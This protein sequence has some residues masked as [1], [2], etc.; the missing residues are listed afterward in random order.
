MI[1]H[2]PG[3]IIAGLAII[4]PTILGVTGLLTSPASSQSSGGVLASV[5]G[6]LTWSPPPGWESYQ[7][8]S[9]EQA[10][11]L[12]RTWNNGVCTALPNNLIIELPAGQPYYG[13]IDLEGGGNIVIIGG[14]IQIP[15]QG[16][17]ASISSRRALK[18]QDCPGQPTRFVHIEGVEIGIEDINAS[19]S[20]GTGVRANF[21]PGCSDLSEGIQIAAPASIIQIQNVRINHIHARD[22]VGQSDN[23]PDLIQTW[24]GYGELRI[25]RFSGTTDY[26]GIFLKV[27]SG[28]PPGGAHLKNVNVVGD[29]TATQLF[30]SHY[31]PGASGIT[32]ENFWVQ[33]ARPTSDESTWRSLNYS[34]FPNSFAVYPDIPVTMTVDGNGQESASWSAGRTPLIVG[35]VYKGIP[36]GDFVPGS[37]AGIGYV[38]PGYAIQVV[39]PAPPPVPVPAPVPTPAP[40]P[41][42][43][44]A[45]ATVPTPE[46]QPTPPSVTPPSPAEPV[47]VAPAPAWSTASGLSQLVATIIAQD[48][49]AT[50]GVVEQGDNS[51]VEPVVGA[52]AGTSPEGEAPQVLG[53]ETVETKSD[54][55]WYLPIAFWLIILLIVLNALMALVR[56]YLVRREQ[57]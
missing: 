34:V 39:P 56:D 44:P 19:C 32:L 26:Q 6:P 54:L 53:A 31:T 3:I 4:I 28:I 48:P 8:V 23:H 15:W 30:W 41:M 7:R 10:P 27:D 9:V 36:G 43:V 14:E 50:V 33:P 57:E 42:P 5:T 25:D 52:D 40:A 29:P 35:S 24:G 12:M 2:L 22:Q 1:K 20:S 16:D 49:Q 13:A 18:I 46:P 51:E 11:E 38:S 21:D 37:V 45:P 55:G 17:G 47:A